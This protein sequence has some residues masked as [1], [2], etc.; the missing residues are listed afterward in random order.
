MSELLI[1]KLTVLSLCAGCKLIGELWW[2]NAQRYIM[3]VVIAAGVC[4][5]LHSFW[6]GLLVLPMIAP[7]CF[8]YKTY[9]NSDGFNRAVWLMAIC[10]FNGLGLTITHHVSWF[11][12]IPWVILSAVWGGTTRNLL[13]I[14]IAPISGAIIG[15]IVFFVH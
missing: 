9:G 15:I 1:V 12:F 10:L 13:N 3:P 4:L 6:L 11:I 7:L 14:I 8:G 2:H 5:V